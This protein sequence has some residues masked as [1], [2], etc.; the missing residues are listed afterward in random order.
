MDDG[1]GEA[2]GRDLPRAQIAHMPRYAQCLEQKSLLASA[3][4]ASFECP[5]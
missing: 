4:F 2:D 3:V 5:S 1:H